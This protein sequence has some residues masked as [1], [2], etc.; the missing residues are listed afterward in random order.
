MVDSAEEFP[1]VFTEFERWMEDLGLGSQ[2]TFA[3]VTDGYA[4]L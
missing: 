2:H 3:F 1:A 4:V